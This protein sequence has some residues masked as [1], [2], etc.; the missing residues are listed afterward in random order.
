MKVGLGLAF[1]IRDLAVSLF[2]I[3]FLLKSDGFGGCPD[4]SEVKRLT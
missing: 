1:V 3:G 2:T 4:T